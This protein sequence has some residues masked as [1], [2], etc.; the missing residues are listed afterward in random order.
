VTVALVIPSPI[1][2]FG[3]EDAN[4]KANCRSEAKSSKDYQI[5]HRVTLRDV[6]QG[7]SERNLDIMR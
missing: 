4:R 1:T 7:R 2:S 3:S 6:K 5:S